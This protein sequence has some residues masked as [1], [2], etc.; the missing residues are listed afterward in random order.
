MPWLGIALLVL[1]LPLAVPAPARAQAAAPQVHLVRKGD[2]LSGIAQRYGVRVADLKRW[3]GL[4][5]DRIVIGRRLALRAGARAKRETVDPLK[6]V[7]STWRESVIDRS[8]RDGSYALVVNKAERRMEVYFSGRLVTTF[9]VGIGYADAQNLVD[10][11]KAEDHHLKEGVFHLSEVAWSD[12]IA[13]WDRV[14]MR[15]HTVEAAKQDY[16]KVYGDRGRRQLAKWEVVHGPVVTD[17]DVQ[18]Y[19]RAH[20]GM[21]I[22]RGLGIHGG[23]AR[24]DWTEGC[25]ALDRKDVRW[26]YGRLS[27]MPNGGIGTPVAVVRF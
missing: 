5:G 23:G 27:G 2:T 8:R 18:E 12:R 16:A 17:Q 22:W 14:W 15:I 7:F 20:R 6:A 13:K 24:Y 25:V 9:P 1:G 26:L 11:Q 3:N 21:T 10:R 19:N 4:K